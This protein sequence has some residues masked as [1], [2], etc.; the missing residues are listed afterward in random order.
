MRSPLIALALAVTVCAGCSKDR[1]AEVA[2]ETARR[3]EFRVALLR[4]A[5][6]NGALEMSSSSEV[7]FQDGFWVMQYD[8]PEDMKGIAFRWIGQNARARLRTHGDKPMDLEL[9]G[10]IHTKVLMTRP[11]VSAYVDGQLVGDS[12]VVPPEGGYG[13]KARVTPDMLRGKTWVDLVLTV[14][15]VSWHWSDPPD[16]RVAH[17]SHFVWTEA[18]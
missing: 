4:D 10:W 18:R 16:V 17:V 5:G 2:A 1:S 13:I 11:V 3:E 8:P 7:L 12:G 15:S 6:A 9:A 14:S